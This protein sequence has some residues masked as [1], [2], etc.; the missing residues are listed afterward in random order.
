MNFPGGASLHFLNAVRENEEDF[1]PQG[2][3]CGS[4]ETCR[5]AAR[6]EGTGSFGR[7]GKIRAKCQPNGALFPHTDGRED[8]GRRRVI[9]SH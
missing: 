1:I 5:K 8:N 9:Q 4:V 2:S 6:S 3:R 7:P